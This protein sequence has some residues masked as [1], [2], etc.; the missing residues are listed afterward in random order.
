[1]V[2]YKRAV[3]SAFIIFFSGVTLLRAQTLPS[4]LVSSDAVGM[5]TALTTVGKCGGAFSLE[6]NAASMAFIDGKVSAGASFGLWQPSYAEDMILGL[7]VACKISERLALG[8]QGKSF[9]QHS[10][11]IVT[12]SG[13]VKSTFTPKD[14][15]FGMGAAYAVTD[16]LSVGIAGR[17][18]KSTLSEDA[19]ATVLGI[20][21]GLF[22]KKNALSAGLSINN[23]GSKVNYGKGSYTQP[24]MLK[25]GVAYTFGRTEGH[26]VTP[27][28]EVDYLL[29]GGL[30][31]G[32]GLEYSMKEFLY[33]RCG[34]HYGDDSQVIPSFAS[35]GLG[36][37]RYGANIDISYIVMSEVLAGSLGISLGYSF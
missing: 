18:V 15:A 6:N 32:L 14:L 13:S 37:K 16:F 23:F 21:A 34:Y 10:Y 36:L 7:G 27:S 28:A 24:S 17:L 25:A 1:M 31:A 29:S 3:L 4:L 20:D 26:S 11:D 9:G 33:V 35:V 22:L 19:S 12:E 2:E 8:I 5:G 30:M